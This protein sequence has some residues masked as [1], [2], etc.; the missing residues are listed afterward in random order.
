MRACQLRW[1]GA[2]LSHT[3]GLGPE[4]AS[5]QSS[6]KLVHSTT[7]ASTS[8]VER[9]D[10]RHVGV[11]DGDG[12]PA[13][14]AQH[15]GGQQRGGGLAV[16]PGDGEHRARPARALLLPL[17]GEVDL[18]AQRHAEARGGDDHGVG[19]GDARAGHDEVAPARPARSIVGA[20]GRLDQLDAERSAHAPRASASGWS[21]ASD[22]VVAA[23]RRSARG[24]RLAG[25]RP[26]P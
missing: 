26:A 16:G 4:A 23:R 13:G 17:V 14:G 3:D 20:V 19:L 11:A 24:D 18:G 15:R 12:A 9:G 10:E 25:D 7:N 21:S 5:I 22:D 1:S 2:R 8:R 6:R